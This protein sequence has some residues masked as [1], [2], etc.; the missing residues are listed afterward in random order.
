MI[1]CKSPWVTRLWPQA[2]LGKNWKAVL[3]GRQRQHESLPLLY[4]RPF[5]TIREIFLS[6]HLF[7]LP[8]AEIASRLPFFDKKA[9]SDQFSKEYSDQRRHLGLQTDTLL[10]HLSL[11]FMHSKI[12]EEKTKT[13]SHTSEL[14]ECSSFSTIFSFAELWRFSFF[15]VRSILN[16]NKITPCLLWKTYHF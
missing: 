11:P 13:C 12:L 6:N 10:C 15:C 14:R 4:C 9:A 8:P 3:K 1:I 2:S 7:P 16:T 5:V